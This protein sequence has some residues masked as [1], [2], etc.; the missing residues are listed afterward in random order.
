VQLLTIVGEPGVGKSRLIGEFRA[1]V[2][3]RPEIV[4]WRQGRCLPYGEG[5]TFW[6]LGEVVKAHAGILESDTVEQAAEKVA[7]AVEAVAAVDTADRDWVAARLRPLVGAADSGGAADRQEAFTAWRT[8]L[9]ALAEERPLVLVVEDL[10]WAD[11]PMLEFL[12]HLVDWAGEVPLLVACTARPEFF[13]RRSDWGGGKRNATMIS[14]KPLSTDETAQLLAALLEETVLPA[15]TQ[16]ALLDRAGG[17]PLYAEEFVRMLLDRGILERHGHAVTLAPG[18]DVPMPETVQAL[19]AARLDTL[20]P[21][22]K[23]LLQDAAVLGKVF[24]SGALAS[25]GDRSE[26]DIRDGLHELAKKELVRPARRSSVEGQSEYAFWHLLIRD[27]AYAQIPRLARATK[28]RNAA[29]WIESMAGD[30]VAD[31]AELLSHHYTEALAL[32]RAAGE[33]EA[34]VELAALAARTLLIAAER[35]MPLDPVRAGSYAETALDLLPDESVERAECLRVA[36][37]ADFATG[38]TE[39]VDQR[40][41]EALRLSRMADDLGVIGKVLSRMSNQA[42]FRGETVRSHS[43]A[44]EAVEILERQGQAEALAEALS[45]LASWVVLSGKSHEGLGI[46]E[47]ALRMS[48]ELD[49]PHLVIRSLQMRGIAR[50]GLGDRRGTDD[51]REAL[52]L[53]LEKGLAALTVVSHINVAYWLWQSEGPESGLQVYRTGIEIGDRW[54]ARSFS[55]WAQAETTWPLFDLGDWDGLLATA[56]DVLEWDRAQGGTQRTVIVSPMKALA[57]LYRGDVVA[58]SALAEEFVPSARAIGDTQAIVPALTV[59]TSIARERGD[60]DQAVAYVDEIERMAAERPPYGYHH[61]L[62]SIRTLTSAGLIDR[63][64]AQLERRQGDVCWARG[65]LLEADGIVAEASGDRETAATMFAEGAVAWPWY[66]HPLEE[67]LS[68]LGAGRSLVAL[69]RPGDADPHLRAALAVFQRL[70]ARPLIS[71]ADG[72]LLESARLTS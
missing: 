53:A 35:L 22:R 17:N 69:G 50:N 45:S 30:R 12:E 62:E 15:E 65:W 43:L 44:A 36:A 26:D 4:W 19:I 8:Y 11:A 32:A 16:Q 33:G 49:I 29:G 3:D 55:T 58:A 57:L 24:W 2:D 60:L 46:S 37:E 67:A 70:R 18:A 23:A 39:R 52:R 68:H 51:L 7:A 6:A 38:R 40:L 13:V 1:W 28:H 14:L 47:R 72:L 27:V 34:A 25:M 42:W 21:D 54:G 56:D 63:A 64:R 31:H 5:I 20:A 59:A 41:E 48:T 61:L 66:G 10:H 9:E 71:K